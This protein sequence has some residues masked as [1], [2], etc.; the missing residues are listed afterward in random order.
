MSG[1]A[2]WRRWR[3]V[4]PLPPG[5]RWPALVQTLVWVLAPVE[6]G[7]FCLRRYGPLFT[8]RIVGY[9]PVVHVC[10]PDT[11]RRVLRTEADRFDA[12]GAN[13][14]V[15]FVVGGHSLLLSSGAAHAARRKV[16]M[17]PLHG[18]NVTHYVALM[19]SIVAR[20]VRGWRVG[21]TVRLLDSCQ[22]ITLEVMMRAVFGI[23]DSARLARL[24]VLVPRLL[25]IN[26]LVILVPAARRHFRG[27]GPWARLL[28]LIA[29][30][31]AI[32]HA[33]LAERRAV[34]HD[35]PDVVSVL[36][37]G[38]E[39]VTDAELRDH[40]VTLLAVGQETTATQLAWLFERV[41]RCPDA[42]R[43]VTSAA[44]R[45]DRQV[46][47]AAINEAVRSRPSTMDVGRIALE[48]WEAGGYR[49]PAGTL[50]AVSLGLLH[51]S[52]ATYPDPERYDLGRC[53]EPG[54]DFLPFGAGSHRCLGA[55]LAMAE[56]RTVVAAV[57]RS[58]R[59]EP[60]RPAAEWARPKGPMLLPHRGAAARVLANHLLDGG[61]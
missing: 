47:D 7:R 8:A 57:L 11:V 9:G 34:P 43:A 55:S 58:A 3:R 25:D 2:P 49:V 48:P 28:A 26:P 33:E 42:L 39:P 1:A 12:A 6:F 31:D 21:T 4:A 20:E 10:A 19:E 50:F 41:L 29:E 5:P 46:L 53:P 52:P 23:T 17:G 15:R 51:R 30:V 54:P 13:E 37:A 24:R 40:L 56:M 61:G 60:D 14:A 27:H 38:G 35:G 59:L 16:L 45:G 22:R 36:L 32:I 44:H 18:A